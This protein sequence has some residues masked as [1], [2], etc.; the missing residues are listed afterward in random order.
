MDQLF[1]YLRTNILSRCH[2]LENLLTGNDVALSTSATRRAMDLTERWIVYDIADVVVWCSSADAPERILS[3]VESY[4]LSLSASASEGLKEG[5][6]T[7]SSSNN[8]VAKGKKGW[9][10]RYSSSIA[11][12]AMCSRLL[13]PM[14][15]GLNTDSAI[16]CNTISLLSQMCLSVL[17]LCGSLLK[18]VSETNGSHRTLQGQ[19]QGQGQGIKKK[20]FLVPLNGKQLIGSVISALCLRKSSSVQTDISHVLDNESTS[21][22]IEGEKCLDEEVTQRFDHSY[23]VLK[24]FLNILKTRWNDLSVRQCTN[25]QDSL[26]VISKITNAEEAVTMRIVCSEDF[27]SALSFMISNKRS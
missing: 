12:I 1:Q 21:D 20:A 18:D 24:S 6:V 13:A 19:G 16:V 11:T 23:F 3:F 25:V 9:M 27:D 15:D 8:G 10:S 4:L 17:S 7:D 26:M 2:G 14:L 22:L 5:L